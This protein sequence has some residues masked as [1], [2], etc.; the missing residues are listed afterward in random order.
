MIYFKGTM[1]PATSD[2]NKWKFLLSVKTMSGD[3]YLDLSVLLIMSA[4]AFDL[5]DL[6]IIS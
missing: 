2:Y 3:N 6:L 5:R 4:K 1:G